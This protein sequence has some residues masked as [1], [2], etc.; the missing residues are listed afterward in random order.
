MCP[1]L[2]RGHSARRAVRRGA[3]RHPA[4]AGRRENHASR[5]PGASTSAGCR[6]TTPS[7]AA[8]SKKWADK[9]G[10]KIELT[11]I[12]DYVES[13]NQYTAG[14]FD[15]CVDDQHG[16]ADHPCRGRRRFDRADRRRLL[17]RQRRRGAQ[18]RR[19]EARRHQGPVGQPGRAVGVALPAGARPRIGRARA[20]AT[21]RS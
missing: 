4:R 14:K 8:S 21:S 15:A 13:I 10:I 6:G 17:Q 11:Q 19:Q 2:L 12:N 5:S 1:P 9:Y 20:S 3:A 18:G 16:H 7:R